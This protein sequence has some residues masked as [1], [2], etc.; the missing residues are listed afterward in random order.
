MG[1]DIWSESIFM[2]YQDNF[3][4]FPNRTF[5]TF[6]NKTFYNSPKNLEWDFVGTDRRDLY[7][8]NLK[9]QPKDW[10]YRT[11]K[12]KY[13]LNSFGY[14]TKEFDQIDWKN[15]IVMFGCSHVFG[16][17]VEEQYSISSLL[18]ELIGIPVIN[19]A[20]DGGS[21]QIMFHNSLV[22]SELYPPPKAIVYFWTS[23]GRFFIYSHDKIESHHVN[24][25]G[26]EYNDLV[27]YANTYNLAI[28]NLM[29]IKYIRNLWKNKTD[30]YELTFF[31]HVSKIL[32]DGC[33]HLI[34]DN[35][36]RDC[37]HQGN[38]KNIEI[39]EKLKQK[40]KL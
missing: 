38:S 6:D 8:K 15:S 21:N 4:Y 28:S 34:A 20:V 9:K 27:G 30:V 25:N 17:G 5:T 12:I 11:A 40:I 39:T 32:N 10:Y 36:A 18:E 7:E 2:N 31:K 37:G 16:T 3:L 19:L 29:L 35:L 13:N 24:T 1:T 23:F 26:D 33:E 22:L 14:R